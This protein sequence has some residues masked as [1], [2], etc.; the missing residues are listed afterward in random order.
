MARP[1]PRDAPV[2]SA[3]LPSSAAIFRNLR[4]RV[5]LSCWMRRTES[6]RE[7]SSIYGQRCT[8]D[9][10]GL[11]RAN[12]HDGIGNLLGETHALAR[13]LCLEEIRFIFLRL[14]EVVEHP[15]F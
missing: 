10:R 7:H 5:L 3:V 9:V 6:A 11:V 13:N 2:T 1:I 14:S 12:E 4:T 8:D 15:C